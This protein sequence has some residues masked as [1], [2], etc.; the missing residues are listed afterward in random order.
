MGTKHIWIVLLGILL[1][2]P[3]FGALDPVLALFGPEGQSLFLVIIVITIAMMAPADSFSM[4]RQS[5]VAVG[6]LVF[7]FV[8]ATYPVL[9]G[10]WHGAA[11]AAGC[12][13][14]T[15]QCYPISLRTIYACGI[16]LLLL[17]MLLAGRSKPTPS[18]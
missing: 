1:I 13:P 4:R 6:F 8:Y 14:A 15:M 17:R 3:F 2:V 11:V 10:T 16:Y 5:L 9:L 7:G 18:G 12:D